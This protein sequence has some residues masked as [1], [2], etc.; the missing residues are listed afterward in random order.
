[1]PDG[2]PPFH[3]RLQEN[4][5]WGSLGLIGAAGDRQHGLRGPRAGARVVSSHQKSWGVVAGKP[6]GGLPKVVQKVHRSSEAG[7]TAD[8]HG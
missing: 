7:E 3:N 4:L 8:H 5:K 6:P 2:E 1:M